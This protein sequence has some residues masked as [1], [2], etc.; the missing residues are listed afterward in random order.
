MYGYYYIEHKNF[1]VKHVFILE[2][3][4]RSTSDPLK[5]TRHCV[6]FKNI[7]MKNN[8]KV[9]LNSLVHLI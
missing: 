6:Y 3:T 4:G 8:Y 2:R 5:H 1:P 9:Y 7:P